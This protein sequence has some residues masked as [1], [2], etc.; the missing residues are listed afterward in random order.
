MKLTS[1]KKTVL[2]K[3]SAYITKHPSSSHNGGI[4]NH[5]FDKHKLLQWEK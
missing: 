1:K 2:L 3:D 4:W 5:F